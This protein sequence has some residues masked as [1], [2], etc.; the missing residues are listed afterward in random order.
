MRKPSTPP[1][2]F[3]IEHQGLG[4]RRWP[5]T[6]WH[7]PL[8]PWGPLRSAALLHAHS[9]THAQSFVFTTTLVRLLVSVPLIALLLASSGTHWRLRTTVG[10]QLSAIV[11]R[12]GGRRT[13][14]L[15]GL[16][17]GFWGRPGAAPGA[18]RSV[19]H[20]R[21]GARSPCRSCDWPIM[22]ALVGGRR[23]RRVLLVGSG[24]VAARVT[25][26]FNARAMSRS[27]VSSMT[28]HG[29]GGMPG[30]TARA[31]PLSASATRR[32]CRCGFSRSPPEDLIEALRPVQGQVAI[33]V[34]P[35]LFDVLPVTATLHDLGSGLTGISVAPAS[36][37]WGS[38]AAKRTMDLLGTG[39]GL[40]PAFAA[41]AVLRSPSRPPPRDP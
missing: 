18:R 27:S 34:V 7:W 5:P 14:L 32:S 20:V 6:R 23:H 33:T 8:P 22:P 41:S 2:E 31:C 25:E 28:T 38:R 13:D 12:I 29:P 24:L 11:A 35:R 4:L 1:V 15:G 36:F 21:H 26:Q 10:E 30:Q 16:A 39:I 17:F 37:G 19:D 3:A 9:T 40:A